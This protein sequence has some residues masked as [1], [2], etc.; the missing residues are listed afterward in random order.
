M[1]I[2]TSLLLML[3]MSCGS[4]KDPEVY[5]D[6]TGD[7]SGSGSGSGGD[8]GSDSEFETKV[9]PILQKRC[10][11]SG[12]HAK[13]AI[14]DLRTEAKYKASNSLSR[15]ND[16]SMPPRQSGPGKGFTSEEKSV[17]VSFLR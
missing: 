3:V 15:I 2:I 16:G 1:K 12:C 5:G 7:N 11:T 10:L 17:L 14:V 8:S 6:Q 4:G 13:G 9:F